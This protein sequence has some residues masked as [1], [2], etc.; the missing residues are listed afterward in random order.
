MCVGVGAVDGADDVAVGEGV[1]D[2]DAVAGEGAAGA[3]AADGAT[4]AGPAAFDPVDSTTR[5][6]ASGGLIDRSP[7]ITA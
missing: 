1:V 5:W 2:G 3:G 7:R 6:I 4:G